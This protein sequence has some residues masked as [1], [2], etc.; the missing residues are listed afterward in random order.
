MSWI[1]N[2]LTPSKVKALKQQ[3]RELE[4]KLEERQEAINK[5][6]AYYKKK[7]H[8]MQRKKAGVHPL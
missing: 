4:A 5:T 2:I 7:I 1:K 3:V 8:D 6:N